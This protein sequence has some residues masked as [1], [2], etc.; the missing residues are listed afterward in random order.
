MKYPLAYLASSDPYK[1]YLDNGMEQMDCKEFLDVAIGEVKSHCKRKHW[2]LLLHAEVP[3]W[4][5]ILESF[6]TMK[7]KRDIVTRQVYKRKESLNVL[8]FQQEYGVNCLET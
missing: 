3:K 7:R 5:H 8:G 4:Q 2:R 6:C 1:M